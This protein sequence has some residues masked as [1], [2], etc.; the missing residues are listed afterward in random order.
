M[1]LKQYDLNNR[2]HRDLA[3]R[4]GIDIPKR[5][6]GKPTKN[7][8]DFVEK[9]DKCWNW[10][11][12]K[13]RDGY[14][15]LS[16]NGKGERVH[17]QVLIQSGIDLGEND[18]VMHTCDNPACCNP[19][20]LKIG[21]HRDNQLDKISKSRQARGEKQ[22]ASKLTEE[23]VLYCRKIYAEGNVTYKE[24]AKAH[25]VC[26]DTMQKAIRRKQWTHI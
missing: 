3:R 6:P 24:L 22:G 13:N 21:T 11:G 10:I 25:G 9:T 2:Y 19:D 14:G 12:Y 16:I 17:R 18:I 1:T 26:K 8:W 5:K 23:E 4:R 15:I 7:I 20:H